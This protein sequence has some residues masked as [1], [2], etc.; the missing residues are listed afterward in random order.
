MLLERMHE[1]AARPLATA[2]EHVDPDASLELTAEG[3]RIL[4]LLWAGPWSARQGEP[5]G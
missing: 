5:T 3:L 1:D 2:P 4:D